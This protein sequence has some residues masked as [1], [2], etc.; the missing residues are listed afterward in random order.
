MIQS[1]YWFHVRK[2]DWYQAEVYE[3]LL[4]CVQQLLFLYIVFFGIIIIF[5]LYSS[6][7]DYLKVL[8]VYLLDIVFPALSITFSI[9]AV[10]LVHIFQIENP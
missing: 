2:Y 6:C 1:T 8:C 5:I 7:W 9:K 3:S 10:L 4:A